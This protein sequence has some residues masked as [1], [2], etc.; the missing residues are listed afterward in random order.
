MKASVWVSAA[1]VALLSAGAASAQSTIHP[2][3][4]DQP[5]STQSAPAESAQAS[6]HDA[7]TS[8]PE[9]GPNATKTQGKASDQY[10]DAIKKDK[11]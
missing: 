4:S 7:Q 6:G 1:A 11:K 9:T 3:T 8:Q 10:K 5:T 2:T